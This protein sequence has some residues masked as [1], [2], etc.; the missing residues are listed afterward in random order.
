[1]DTSI[2]RYF[3]F[4]M[5]VIFAFMTNVGLWSDHSN[6]L[7]HE[8][9]HSVNV[10]P[11]TDTANYVALHDVDSAEINSATSGLAVEHE[12][13]HAADH[14]LNRPEFLRHSQASRSTAFHS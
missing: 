12:L 5:L 6:W 9:E 10:T 13:L 4:A 8:L 7:T 2:T 1:M 11:M 3:T 14:L